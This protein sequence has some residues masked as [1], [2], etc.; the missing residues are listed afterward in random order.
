MKLPDISEIRSRNPHNDSGSKKTLHQ[1]YQ[2]SLLFPSKDHSH[3]L[4]N[5]KPNDSSTSIVASEHSNAIN[6]SSLKM[7]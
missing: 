6:S 3:S 5:L 1:K 7:L 4:I 2:S